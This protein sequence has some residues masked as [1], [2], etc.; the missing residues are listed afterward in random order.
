MLNTIKIVNKPKSFLDDC[1]KESLYKISNIE[2]RGDVADF[3]IQYMDPIIYGDQVVSYIRLKYSESDELAVLR[4][5]DTK[6]DEFNT[7]FTYAEECKVK[8]KADIEEYNNFYDI[9]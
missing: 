2:I 5:R 3:T 9:N 8:A 6:I 7:Y 1:L 4:Q